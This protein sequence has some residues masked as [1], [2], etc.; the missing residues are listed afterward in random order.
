M[1]LPIQGLPDPGPGLRLHLNE[2]TGGCS[3]RAVEA[4]R[5]LDPLSLAIYPDYRPAV[6]ETAARLDLPPEQVL[7]TNGLDEGILLVA[8]A[9]FGG[10]VPGEGEAVVPLPAFETYLTV[11]SALGARLVSVPPE[12]DLVF[13]VAGILRALTPA[14][15]LVF[16]N[17][18][19]NPSGRVV[20]LE[21]VRRIAAAARDAVVFVDEAYIEFGGES[22][23][24]E[25]ATWPNLVV[26]RTF[27]KAYGLAGIRIGLLAAQPTLLERVRPIVP[28]F[29]LN[30][31]A[32]AALRAALA[33]DT[34][35][36]W[37]V[38]QAA[39][40]KALLY[41]ACDRLGLRYWRSA[42]N[43][44][45]VDGGARARAIVDGLRA[46]RIFV[47]DRTSDP[48]CPNCFR[49]TAGPVEHTRE[50]IRALEDVC[51]AL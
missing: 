12:P 11:C 4:I 17:N 38:A 3:P 16:V 42:A 8:L 32:V 5:R 31:A 33:D 40:S 51:G 28:L 9:L 6:L 7:L 1:T 22:A 14:T 35:V 21:D 48:W 46:R 45:L 44:V 15:R 13:P 47:R 20:A 50:A 2:H 34:F 19:H 43:F 10:R 37:S 24:G 36:P 25:I 30:A 39:E 26:G 49:I 29:N 18:P 23:L 27:S 41:A